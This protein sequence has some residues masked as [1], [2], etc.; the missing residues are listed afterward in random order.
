[1]QYEQQTN[2]NTN[3]QAKSMD[4]SP[5]SKANVSFAP[6]SLLFELQFQTSK[7]LLL[8]IGDRGGVVVENKMVCVVETSIRVS[9]EVSIMLGTDKG[10]VVASPAA[11]R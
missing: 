3:K 7:L 9:V 5:S 10:D 4:L 6:Q 11:V 8:P 1:M 2:V